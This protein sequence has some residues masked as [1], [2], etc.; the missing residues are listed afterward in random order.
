M[1]FEKKHST[2]LK[3]NQELSD[4]KHEEGTRSLADSFRER[5]SASMSNVQILG[6]NQ[7][8]QTQLRDAYTAVTI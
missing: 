3:R 4:S 6:L 1:Q 8:L 7:N 5:R 2:E